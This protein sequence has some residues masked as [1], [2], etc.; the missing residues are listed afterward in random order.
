M[1]IELN[2]DE[3]NLVIECI[4]ESK[5]NLLE[6]LESYWDVSFTLRSDF[7]D[8]LT[9]YLYSLYVLKFKLCNYSTEFKEEN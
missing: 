9:D 5:N 7:T 3:L 4:T 1:N 2:Q 8:F 6:L